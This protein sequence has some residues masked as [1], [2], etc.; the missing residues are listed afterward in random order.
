VLT[1]IAGS[2]IVIG[3]AYMLWAL[4]KVF[5][6]K[7]NPKWEGPWDPTGKY[8]KHDD[9]NIIEKAALVPLAIIIIVLG[10]QPHLVLDMMTASVNQLINFML[11]FN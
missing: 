10:I 8:Y 3:A 6:G 11:P 1:I 7:Q 9:V 5:F 2:G 4:Q